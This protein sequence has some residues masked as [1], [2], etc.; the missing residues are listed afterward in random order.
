MVESRLDGVIPNS[1][2]SP[3]VAY[4]PWHI[5]CSIYT[6]HMENMQ[7]VR[8]ARERVVVS[9]YTWDGCIDRTALQ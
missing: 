3:S 1:A 7:R 6:M 2:R 5:T 9:T 4:H 8:C